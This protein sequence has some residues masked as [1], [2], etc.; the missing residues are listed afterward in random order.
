MNK[1]I[2][3]DG[4]T[5]AFDRYGQGAPVILVGGAFQHRL[6]DPQT[7]QLAQLLAQHPFTVYH[8]DRRGRGDSGD[9]S[10]YAVEREVDDLAALIA[11]A[12]GQAHVF[13]MSSGGVLA[14]EAAARGLPITRLAVYELPFNLADSARSASQAYTT[15]LTTLLAEGR[16]GD[17]VAL[18][19]TKFGAPAEAV[20]GMR[21]APVWPLFESVAPT[22]AYDATLM[23]DESVPSDRLAAVTVP[24]L[25]MYGGASPEWMRDAAHAVADVLGV[26]GRSLEGQTHDVDPKILAAELEEFF[27][28]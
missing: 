26:R 13:G 12:G 16:R 6:I 4:T 11:E 3:S 19:L 9:T 14:L 27:V 7:A 8:Y 24:T 15:K 18:A 10:P 2:S 21:Q 25:V 20:A 5:I 23:G 1:V 17:A 22:L 28:G